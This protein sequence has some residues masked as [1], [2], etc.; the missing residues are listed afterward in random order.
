EDELSRTPHARILG[1]PPSQLERGVGFDGR[2]Q[3]A[4][5]LVI[6]RPATIRLLAQI[7]VANDV[8]PAGVIA[9]AQEVHQHDV[10]RLDGDV[11]LQL[12]APPALEALPLQQPGYGR[13]E[14]DS[15]S[16]AQVLRGRLA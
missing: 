10:L 2:A 11:G 16:L 13:V 14:H 4:W 3:I 5:P 1:I 12:T 7:D 9:Q 6:D 15:R 8:R